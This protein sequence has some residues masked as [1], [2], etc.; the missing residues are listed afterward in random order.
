LSEL[1]IKKLES[2]P[3]IVAKDL[4]SYKGLRSNMGFTCEYHGDFTCY[5]AS[6]FNSYSGCQGCKSY[7]NG[8]EFIEK[9]KTL[10]GNK[11]I[12]DVKDYVCS[13]TKMKMFCTKHNKIFTLRPSAH[14]QGQNCSECGFENTGDTKKDIGLIKFLERCHAKF[15]D[16]FDYSAVDYSTTLQNVDIICKDHGLFKLSPVKHLSSNTGCIHCDKELEQKQK[17]IDFIDKLNNLRPDKFDT[18]EVV[19]VNNTTRVKLKCIE[20]DEWFS[21]TPLRMLDPSRRCSCKTCYDLSSNRWSIESVLKI[22]DVHERVGY[23]YIGNISDVSGFKVGV[24]ESLESRLHVYND[25]LKTYPNNFNYVFSYKTTYIKA[26]I[27][28]ELVKNIFRKNRFKES[29]IKF[30]GYTEMFDL[31]LPVLIGLVENLINDDVEG[32]TSDKDEKFKLLVE[33]YRENYE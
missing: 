6:I 19:Y 13:R 24:C 4:S 25:D 9:A 30:G 3:H 32:V 2:L 16:K 22:P 14:L 12:Y 11:Y 31:D 17:N 5:P 8:L 10:H 29:S 21:Q 1:F 23:I 20:H 28:E 18:S 33:K 15:S 27:I 26:Y 7:K